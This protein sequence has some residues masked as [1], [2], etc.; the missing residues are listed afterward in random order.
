MVKAKVSPER[1]AQLI[2]WLTD[3][4]QEQALRWPLFAASVSQRQYIAA[5]LPH[6]LRSKYWQ[7]RD[8]DQ[9]AVTRW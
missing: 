3:R 4:Y 8:M 9:K 6:M 1:R 7:T 5:N 2:E